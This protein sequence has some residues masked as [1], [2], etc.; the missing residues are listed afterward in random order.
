MPAIRQKLRFLTK[1]TTNQ[2]T[3]TMAIIQ[4]PT[5]NGFDTGAL[6]PAGTFVATCLDIQD[7]FGVDRPKFENPQ[8]TEKLDITRFLFGFSGQD[9]QT[10]KVQSFEF[11]ISGSPKS[12]LIKFLTSWLGSPPKYGWDYCE[13]KAQGAMITVAHKQSRDGTKTYA[14]IVGISPVIDQLKAQV[15]PIEAFA[16]AQASNAAPSQS[17][18]PSANSAVNPPQQSWNPAVDSQDNCPF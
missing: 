18:P 6:A 3:N 14:N 5:A 12:N 4:E 1:T 17:P 15:L 11:R 10:Y 16:Q 9:N 7:Q 13:L 2:D 8:E